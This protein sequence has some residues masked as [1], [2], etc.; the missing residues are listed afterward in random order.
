MN[1][2]LLPAL[3][4]LFATAVIFSAC[5]PQGNATSAASQG[6]A[7]DSSAANTH[8]TI[9]NIVYINT[10]TLINNYNMFK[11]MS[12]KYEEH[13]TKVQNELD[14]RT[15]SWERKVNELQEKASKGLI[16]RSQGEEMQNNLAKEQQS[17]IEY[18]DKA[19]AELQE[20]ES[21]MFNNV[22]HNI[23]EFLKKYNEEK[24]YDLILST[25]SVTNAV[26]LGN[27]DLD[28]TMEVLEGM[29]KEYAA[30]LKDSSNNKETNSTTKK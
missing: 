26:W 2:K 9:A 23:D 20:E 11:D 12:A 5:N 10:D 16:T 4:V 29:N 28:V 24:K 30:T 21:V 19:L 17:L 1:N 27:P 22:R 15:R 8:R 14:T 7:A 6:N 18:R 3:S 25:S 13:A